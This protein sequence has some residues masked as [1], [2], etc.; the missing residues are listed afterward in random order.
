MVHRFQRQTA[1]VN[2][3]QYRLDSFCNWI[4]V[5]HIHSVLAQIELR[6]RYGQPHCFMSPLSY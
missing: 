5:E 6:Y 2:F 1:Q 3:Q 4:E